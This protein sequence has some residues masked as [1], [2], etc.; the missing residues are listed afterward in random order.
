MTGAAP[1]PAITAQAGLRA[2]PP[3]SAGPRSATGC[4]LSSSCPAAASRCLCEPLGLT[5]R[6]EPSFLL[7]LAEASECSCF[8]GYQN[9]K[10]PGGV[11][12]R[13]WASQAG[14]V[15]RAP[16][17]A[18]FWLLGV[19]FFPLPSNPSESLRD[20]HCCRCLIF[21]NVLGFFFFFF[22]RERLGYLFF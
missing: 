21:L 6:P 20:P 9:L 7:A 22:F 2:A 10:P 1:A 12:I 13:V 18:L 5:Q 16:A 4:I 8:D 11:G 14:C 15:L 17:V 3:S 19:E